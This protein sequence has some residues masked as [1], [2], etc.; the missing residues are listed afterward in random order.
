MGIAL[1]HPVTT[2]TTTTYT[3][4]PSISS[5][6][7]G[8]DTDD[9]RAAQTVGGGLREPR[10]TCDSL[11]TLSV[12]A[13]TMQ[14]CRVLMEDT[15]I[16]EDVVQ[17][18]GT[19]VGVYAVFDGHNGSGRETKDDDVVD[20]RDTA[21]VGGT[22]DD[23]CIVSKFLRDNFV[24]VFKETY[25]EYHALAALARAV[26]TGDDGANGDAEP[27]LKKRVAPSTRVRTRA[28]M[29]K[30]DEEVR[31]ID[32]AVFELYRK[33]LTA[34]FHK[35]DTM[36]PPNTREGSTACVVVATPTMFICANTGDSA[37]VIV[38]NTSEN[39]FIKTTDHTPTDPAERARIERCGFS[40]CD[41][42]VDGSL[43]MSR[44]FGQSPFKNKRIEGNTV[45]DAAVA[46]DAENLYA[47][48][49]TAVICTP[50]VTRFGRMTHNIDYIVVCTD[51]VTER[52]TVDRV[53]DGIDQVFRDG[54]DDLAAV[55]AAFE[56]AL[57]SGSTDNMT[58]IVVRPIYF[59]PAS[60]SL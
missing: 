32:N 26:A 39:G 10:V 29:R 2:K 48:P 7:P 20:G 57:A 24:A 21:A 13:C 44:A 9:V 34:T 16:C 35:L 33:T 18:D 19:R 54:G 28:Q 46:A 38:T 59:Q 25:A 27:P 41:K 51:G 22:G 6:V 52:Q 60:R 23:A 49:P 47:P 45:V 53:V 43:A 4:H 56:Q 1:S 14:G 8:V 15:Y 12:T 58:A 30:V 3:S 5:A 31:N 17:H 42:R 37:C 11:D 55:H 36:L 50:D 40:V